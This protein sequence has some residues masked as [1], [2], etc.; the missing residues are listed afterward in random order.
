M[1]IKLFLYCQMSG[2]F[3][4]NKCPK[5][6]DWKQNLLFVHKYLNRLSWIYCQLLKLIKARGQS[7]MFSL[8]GPAK[9]KACKSFH[10]K[11]PNRTLVWFCVH[12]YSSITLQHSSS[13]K[14]IICKYLLYFALRL[15]NTIIQLFLFL[16]CN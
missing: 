14:Y 12:F 13:G 9:E 8:V 16:L 1:G 10:L 7:T 4:N 11:V 6:N 3:L 5:I 15:L 2:F